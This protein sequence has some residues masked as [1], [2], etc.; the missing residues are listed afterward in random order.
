MCYNANGL[1]Y[2]KTKVLNR[3]RKF[4]LD[5]GASASIIFQ[6]TLNEKVRIDN[7]KKVNIKGINGSIISEGST[8]LEV[9]LGD[10]VIL[11]EFIVVNDKSATI[12]GIIGADFMVLYSAVLDF[13]KFSFTFGPS[14]SRVTVPIIP[15]EEVL[16]ILPPRSEIIKNFSVNTEEDCIVLSNEICEGVFVANIL[17]RPIN[18][19]IPVRILNTRNEAV[20][21][22]NYVPSI[23]PLSKFHICSFG[24]TEN[25]S[26]D[27]ILALSKQ[28]NLNHL[29]STER[30][31]IEN[32]TAKYSDVFQLDGD[33]ISVTDVFEQTIR[34]KP[35]AIPSYSKPYRL[36]PSQ[37]EEIN[38]QTDS[39]NA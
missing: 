5:S 17:A 13:E 10:A 23:E 1:N 27:R 32:I 30:N 25:K 24:E 28:L 2:V 20:K 7:R 35:F 6:K 38:R 29:E 16:T 15:R 34:L 39:K 21:I 14:F 36:P 9:R 31:S 37:K 33:P 8:I 18:G 4:L 3:N 22:C 19:N 26:I 12:E 11:H